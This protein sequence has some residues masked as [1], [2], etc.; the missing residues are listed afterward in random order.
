MHGPSMHRQDCECFIFNINHRS[1]VWIFD[2]HAR[3]SVI[4][5]VDEALTVLPVH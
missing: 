1:S 5:V 3:W 4:D 2:I